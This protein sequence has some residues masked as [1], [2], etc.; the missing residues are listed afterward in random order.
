MVADL[1]RAGLLINRSGAGGGCRLALPPDEIS[2]LEVVEALEGPILRDVCVLDRRRCP[3]DG[4]CGLHDSWARVR[5]AV[6][7]AL[8]SVTLADLQRADRTPVSR[9]GAR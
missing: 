6:L 1:G 9:G 5:S 7:E 2:A 3:D 4:N 8:G